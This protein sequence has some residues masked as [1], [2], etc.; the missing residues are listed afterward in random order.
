MSSSLK[1]ASGPPDTR[2]S[3]L[4]TPFYDPLLSYQ[5]NYDLGPFGPFAEQPSHEIL[6]ALALPEPKWVTVGGLRLRRPVG[7]PSGPLLNSKFT[8]AA[9]RWGFDLCHYKTVRSRQWPSHPAPNVLHVETTGPISPAK[10]GRT[11][12]KARPF[13]PDEPVDVHALSITN[14]FGMPAQPPGI[15]QADMERAARKAGPGQALIAS[16]TGTTA[17][18]STQADFVADHASA[19]SMC[20]ETGAHAIEV[21]LSCPN[22]GGHGLLCHDPQTAQDVCRA[23][24]QAIGSRPLFAKIGSYPVDEAGEATLR[25]IVAATAPYVQGYGAVNAVPVPI[26][27]S[28]GEQAL[29]GA[30]RNMAGVCGAALRA[31]GLDIVDRLA[32]IR[33]ERG[34]DYAIIGVGGFLTPE[35]YFSYRDAGA[36]AVQGATGPMWDHLLAV[37]VATTTEM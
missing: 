18:G 23:V 31:V 9:F 27:T 22:Q 13:R 34:Y 24:R 26:I 25:A 16:V 14:S 7:I 4:G 30:G 29:P 10:M 20:A 19:A 6:T 12:L 37:R 33:I 35:D 3:A 28:A 15:W 36:D 5:D 8:D 11:S 32:R 21:N 2:H 1:H 17:P